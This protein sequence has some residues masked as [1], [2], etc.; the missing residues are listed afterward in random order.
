M[1]DRYWV[2]GTGTW[3][4][5]STTN[6]STTSGG[7]GGASAPTYADNVIFDSLS[8]ATLYSVTFGQGFTGTGSISGTTLTITA[9][10]A[11]TLAAGA[12][13][14]R[15]A[16]LPQPTDTTYIRGGTYIVNQLTGITGG[17]GTYTVNISQTVTS[18]AIGTGA[19]CADLT[20]AAPLT[21]TVTFTS[22]SSNPS[23][24]IYGS[25]TLP[26]ANMTWPALVEV[27]FCASSTGKTI[28]T[29]GIGIGMGNAKC[30]TFDGTGGGWTLGSALTSLFGSTSSGVRVISGGFTTANYAITSPRL[31]S[32]GTS[33]RSISLGSSTVTLSGATPI[34]FT[35]TGL[36]LTAG[37]STITS[38]G[39]NFTFVGGGNTFYNVSFTRTVADTNTISGSNTFNNL[40]F[41]NR[42]TTGLDRI[43]FS[44]DQTVNGALSLGAY[45][46]NQTFR[47]FFKSD[48][49]GIQRNL[50]VASATAFGNAD[51]QDI[52]VGGAASPISG[53]G[54]GNAGNNSGITFSTPKTVYYNATAGSS[55]VNTVWALTS[56]GT[57]SNVNFPLVQ[58]TA[59]IGDTGL[60]S[61]ATITNSAS[62]L[63]GRVDFSTRT[64]PMTWALTSVPLFYGPLFLSSA[65]TITGQT[66]PTGTAAGTYTISGLASGTVLVSATATGTLTITGTAIGN[67]IAGGIAA[68]SLTI[69]GTSSGTVKITAGADGTLD[70]TGASAGTVAIAAAASGTLT[71]TGTSTGG[72][73]VK[74]AASGSLTITGKAHGTGPLHMF[75]G[76]K[77]II[78]AYYGNQA[79]SRIYVGETIVLS[80]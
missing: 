40:S 72:V 42:N 46:S 27:V 24:N 57:P 61:G 1:A 14:N 49:P 71:I 68:G 45:N 19:S 51:F 26:S 15:N 78:G 59:I 73:L 44:A 54:I 76:T 33:T 60:N 77:G 67:A 69:T 4:A 16:S 79:I 30:I 50:T 29:N 12:T 58:D 13:I 56:G 74:A 7:A 11:N 80:S 34:N 48:V 41:A 8:N 64:L 2:G 70:I 6:W 31:E 3:D 17:I 53:T 62:M 23:I 75:Y 39:S 21:G 25:M 36:T 5:V 10:T 47:R 55:W 28:T 18:T 52:V 32:L 9:A 66:V 37:T 35:S 38:S 63:M 43:S 20:V 65:V 22:A